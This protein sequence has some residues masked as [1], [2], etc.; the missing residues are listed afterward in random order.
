M[1][2]RCQLQSPRGKLD[3]LSHHPA[4]F[5]GCLRPG[6]LLRVICIR[7]RS[8]QRG[9]QIGVFI[10]V[11]QHNGVIP[12]SGPFLVLHG[13]SDSSDGV[14][15]QAD[16]ST[17]RD[18]LCQVVVLAQ[19]GQVARVGRASARGPRH[20]PGTPSGSIL[21]AVH[22][23]LS[24]FLP[25]ELF[26]INVVVDDSKGLEDVFIEV[27]VVADP[28]RRTRVGCRREWVRSAETEGQLCCSLTVRSTRPPSVRAWRSSSEESSISR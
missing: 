1:A 12:V 19:L 9:L 18:S 17:P 24:L 7:F 25:S 15:F 26:M 28:G 5:L 11:E 22:L 3:S 8:C 16:V 23:P 13:Q 21:S 27:R 20:L 6:T 4:L 14:R 10:V 2:L